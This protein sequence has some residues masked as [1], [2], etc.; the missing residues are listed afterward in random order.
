MLIRGKALVCV[1]VVSLSGCSLLFTTSPPEHVSAYTTLD[2]TTSRA[3]P[4]IDATLGVLSAIGTAAETSQHYKPEYIAIAMGW[5][6]L[7]SISAIYG[8]GVVRDCGE[9]HEKHDALI[10]QEVLKGRRQ[11]WMQQQ[12]PPAPPGY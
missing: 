11:Q 5:T 6:A 4:G 12:P 7:Y 9:A 1:A 3:A 2:C 10:E 8:F